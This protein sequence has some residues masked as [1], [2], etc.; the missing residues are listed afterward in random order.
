MLAFLTAIQSATIWAAALTVVHFLVMGL[1]SAHVVLTKRDNR[2]AIGWVGIILLTPFIGAALYVMFGVNRIQRRALRLARLT[3]H[4]PKASLPAQP[5]SDVEL[6]ESLGSASQ[7]LLPLTDFVHRIVHQPLLRGNALQLLRDGDTAYGQMLAAIDDAKESIGLCTYIFDNDETGRK[8]AAALGR[9]VERGVEV[10]VLIDDVGTRYT[11]PTI[12][13]HLRAAK[14]PHATFLPTLLPWKLHYTNLRNHRKILVIDG[15]LGF[16]GGMN[17]RQGH[18]TEQPGSYPIV[19]LH[20]RL[21]GPVV[22]Q[23]Q[24][25]FALDWEF[26][27]G[28]ALD[29][30]LWFPSIELVGDSLCRGIADGPDLNS[31]KIQ[32]TLLGAIACAQRSITIVTPYFLPDH[33]LITA[34]NVAD[35]RGV[36][37]RVI[38]PERNNLRLVQWASTAQLWQILRRGVRVFLTPPPFD[39]TKAMLVDDGWSF[40]G[41]ANWDPRSLRLNFEFNVECYD[42]AFTQQLRALI[43]A[44]LARAHEITL[45]DVDG[46]PLWMRLRDGVARLAT[47]YL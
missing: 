12:K 5:M 34:L 24:D 11:F 31:D 37:V 23:L 1:A 36:D 16:T 33:A 3:T 29:G 47:P 30:P 40:I 7:Q 25:T 26:C 13:R 8:F 4:L 10:R 27:T 15:R 32:L 18:C 45:S 35:L 2:A 14:V 39:H 43:D 41:S 46:R 22:A 42:R 9:A 44:K 21:A 19:D 38:L 6:R 20:F 17:I 28:E